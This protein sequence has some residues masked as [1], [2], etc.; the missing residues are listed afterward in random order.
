MS[1]SQ[2]FHNRSMDCA[3]QALLAKF[4]HDQGESKRFFQEA[5]EYELKAIKKMRDNPVEPTF[6]VLH[7]SAATL[8][9]DCNDP[10]LAERLIA[11]ALSREFIPT[12]IREELRDLLEQVYFHRH[13]LLRGIDLGEEELQLSLSGKSVGF[14]VI[15]STEFL[16]RVE[17][18]SRFIIRNVDRRQGREFQATGRPK[19]AIVD[20]YGAFLSV[21]R[22]A[23]FAVTL[24]FGHPSPQGK[25]PGVSD[26]PQIIDDFMDFM[27]FLSVG[28]YSAI[29]AAIP[30]E[31]YRDC[32]HHLGKSLAP[33]GENITM[34]GFTTQRSGKSRFVEVTRPQRD[35]VIPPKRIVG[36]SEE[37]LVEV[38]GILKYADATHGDSGQIKIIDNQGNATQIKVQEE[39]LRETVKDFWES[40]VVV[41]GRGTV[42][43]I[44]T[45]ESIELET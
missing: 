25:L 1:T 42:K 44:T 34:V 13:L 2:E 32:F 35:I 5:L 6:S 38:R 8:A 43:S 27:S 36:D 17:K 16:T 11:A 21:P 29:E 12:E 15:P 24:K 39:M 20:D 40:K 7:Q 37:M 45:L 10:E 3:E 33:D 14:G 28:D 30:E 18:V 41:S 4:R 23:S 9:M 31:P 19:K 26:T 22:A